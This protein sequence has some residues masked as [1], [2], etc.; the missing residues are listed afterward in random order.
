MKRLLLCLALLAAAG[1][2]KKDPAP[3][4]PA[5]HTHVAPHGGTAVVLGAELYHLELVRDATAGRLTAYVLDGEMENFVRV[6]TPSFEVIAAPNGH[7]QSLRFT[8]VANTATGET[9]TD[10]SQFEAQADWLKSTAIFDATLMRLE[11][12]GTVFTAVPFNFP[13]GNDHD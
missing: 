9:L 12:R 4:A 6:N 1:C 8:P 10:T 3:A 13:R 5:H 2:T 11:I 7:P